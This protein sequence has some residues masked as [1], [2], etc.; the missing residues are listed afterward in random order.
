MNKQDQLMKWLQRNMFNVVIMVV[1][2]F[3]AVKVHSTQQSELAEITRQRD[4]EKEK[5]DILAQIA[6]SEKLLKKSARFI[7]SKQ[8]DTLIDDIN[9]KAA[10]A[11]I[12]IQQLNPRPEEKLPGNIYKKYAYDLSIVAPSYHAIGLFIN[13]LEKAPALYTVDAIAFRSEYERERNKFK[14][15][16]TM[17]VSTLWLME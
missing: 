2:V 16:A 9:M 15:V 8:L 14:V 12:S 10:A 4:E 7:N 5:N 6:Q 3:I 11:G 17:T 13:S 1:F